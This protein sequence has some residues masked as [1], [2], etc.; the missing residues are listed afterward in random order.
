MLSA[1]GTDVDP[2]LTAGQ[3]KWQ[4]IRTLIVAPY[5]GASRSGQRGGWNPRLA[6]TI[7]YAEVSQ[8][9][10][11][12]LP[13]PGTNESILRFDQLQP[14]GRHHEA[15]QAT[16]YRLSSEAMDVVE[17]W[18]EWYLFGREDPDG[19]L[20]LAREELFKFSE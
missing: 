11:D 9:F 20:R 8:L 6:Q 4:R 13:I 18:L 17:E 2:A 15:F 10:W 16:P 1:G 12:K 14:I 3:G 7:K 19:V 5:F